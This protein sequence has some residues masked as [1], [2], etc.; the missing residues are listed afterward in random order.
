MNSVKKLTKNTV[1]L[2]ITQ[3]ISKILSFILIIFIAKHL[4]DV[5]LGKYSFVLAFTGLFVI[6][7]D[8]GLN[9]LTIREVA[10][11]K[12][13]ARKYLINVSLIKLFLSI[14]TFGLIFFVINLMNYPQETTLAVYIIGLSVILHSFAQMFHSIFRA[15]ERMEFESIAVIT[16]RVVVFGLGVWVLILGYGLIEV[17]F[18]VLIGSIINVLISL[19]ITIKKVIKPIISIDWK[20]WKNLMQEALPFGL[21]GVFVMIYFQIDTVMLSIM[22]GDATVGW[23]NAAYK[24]I[25]ALQIFP[26]SFVGSLFPIISRFYVSSKDSLKIAYEKSFKYLFIV[27]LPIAVSTTLLGDKI[28]LFIYGKE[29]VHSIIALKILIWVA[30]FMFITY[31]FGTVLGSI[32]KQTAIAKVCGINALI[33]IFLNIL[34]I[35][36]FSYVGA[37][38]ATVATEAVGFLLLF[39]YISK[40][41][42]TLPLLKLTVKPIIA[43]LSIGLFISYF[44]DINLLLL[45][46]LAI[47]LY[48]AL[49]YLLKTFPHEDVDLLIKVFK[50]E[51]NI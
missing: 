16:E 22:K 26:V 11:N 12:N 37:S 25:F 19:Y 46:I 23:Y 8:I 30:T 13:K 21:V 9:Q 2:T 15:F 50:K 24:L 10:R 36:R 27:G 51:T 1:L 48:F 20:S 33:N 28:I 38:V 3:L 47:I 39:F 35:P 42:Y 40:H 32:N 45:I 4:G 41:F 31:L 17:V 43:S 34:L 29:F 14:L 7:S 5:G 49:L 18:A 6:F 44:K